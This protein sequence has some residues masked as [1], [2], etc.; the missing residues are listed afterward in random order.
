MCR[1]VCR[2]SI[3][4]SVGSEEIPEGR[5]SVPRASAALGHAPTRPVVV[6]GPRRIAPDFVVDR[7]HRSRP[8]RGEQ[9]PARDHAAQRAACPRPRRPGPRSDE[10][11]RPEIGELLHA[12]A[13]PH[14]RRAAV[15][16]AATTSRRRA[17]PSGAS[18]SIGAET[19]LVD[20]C[21]RRAR[22]GAAEERRPSRRGRLPTDR[23]P[24]FPLRR[25][26]AE[27]ETGALLGARGRPRHPGAAG[28]VRTPARPCAAGYRPSATR[29]RRATSGE[30]PATSARSPGASTQRTPRR[31]VSSA[32]RCA[33]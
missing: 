2:W 3:R 27:V 5:A 23:G 16:K 14:R 13:H 10:R 25:Q 19:M 22:P 8:E 6:D 12:R 33:S 15:P 20:V 11:R 28:R 1:A 29:T 32:R 4:R 26:L 17:A 21:A 24:A 31:D 18:D 9:M 30:T 7:I